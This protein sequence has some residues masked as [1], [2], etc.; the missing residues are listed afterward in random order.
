MFTPELFTVLLFCVILF[1]IFLLFRFLL[2]SVDTALTV[3]IVVILV[4][5]LWFVVAYIFGDA[6]KNSTDNMFVYPAYYEDF[7][8]VYL[9]TGQRDIDWFGGLW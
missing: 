4:F 6:R 9:E 8:G 7:P 2:D 5:V 1:C 3:I